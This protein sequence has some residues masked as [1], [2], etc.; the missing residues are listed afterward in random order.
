MNKSFINFNGP[1]PILMIQKMTWK[2]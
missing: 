2:I 1:E